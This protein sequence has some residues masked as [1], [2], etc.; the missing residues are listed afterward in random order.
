MIDLLPGYGPTRIQRF[1]P[2]PFVG[3]F[4]PNFKDV[5][6]S[7]AVKAR[8]DFGLERVD[9]VVGNVWDLL[10]SVR[11]SYRGSSWLFAVSLRT[12]ENRRYRRV[13]GPVAAAETVAIEKSI[14][15]EGSTPHLTVTGWQTLDRCPGLPCH[16]TPGAYGTCLP[17]EYRGV[18][19]L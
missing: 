3:A 11:C 14:D 17:Q 18:S 10:E 5:E 1:P 15:V 19:L 13:R 7:A 9:H 2:Q 4:L 12:A 8:G 16:A 6:P